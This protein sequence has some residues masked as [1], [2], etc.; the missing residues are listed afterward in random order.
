V[1]GDDITEITPG[2]SESTFA[3]AGLKEPLSLTF[4]S[5][6]DLFVG[7]GG[8]DYI[9]EYMPDGIRSDFA[10]GVDSPAGLAFNSTGDLFEADYGTGN[11]YEFTPGGVSLFASGL[12]QP[13]GLAFNNAGNLFV[14]DQGDG[15]IT[16]ITPEGVQ[17]TFASGLGK[18]YGLAFQGVTLPV[19]E[20]SSLGVLVVG[21]TALLIRHRS[22]LAN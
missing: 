10:S 21:A 5:T 2:G 20:P 9:Y 3:S 18:V 19:P 13:F 11:I 22:K 1:N 6:G 7:N 8:I 4:N 14:A 16:E 12:N 17:S 15:T